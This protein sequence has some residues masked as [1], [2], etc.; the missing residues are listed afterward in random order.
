[1]KGSSSFIKLDTVVK[2][3][4]FTNNSNEIEGNVEK[5]TMVLKVVFC[6]KT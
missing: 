3:I 2:N 4:R 5:A 6:N 1:M